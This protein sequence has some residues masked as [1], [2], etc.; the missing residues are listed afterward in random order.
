MTMGVPG[1]RFENPLDLGSQVAKVYS[2]H[3]ITRLQLSCNSARSKPRTSDCAWFGT[4]LF[5]RVN[6]ASDGGR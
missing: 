6:A 3:R 2:R 5:A 1:L 4:G